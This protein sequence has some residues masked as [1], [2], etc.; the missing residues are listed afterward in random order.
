MTIDRR[1]LFTALG[2]AGAVAAW[3]RIAFANGPT[4]KR[5]VVV[6]LRGAMDGLTAVPAHG[7]PAYERARNGIATPRPGD[8]GGA[9]ALDGMFGLHPALAHMHARHNALTH[10]VGR[11]AGGFPC[12]RVARVPPRR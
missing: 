11:G 10:T 5:F 8:P 4:D 2:A 6:I 1:G 3:P 7:D 9:L 12:P